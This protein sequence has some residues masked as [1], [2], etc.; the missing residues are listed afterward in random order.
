[1][2]RSK[3]EYAAMA[4]VPIA[5]DKILSKPETLKSLRSIIGL[6]QKSN[7]NGS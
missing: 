5:F 7:T 4:T 3:I 1:M 6:L 2:D